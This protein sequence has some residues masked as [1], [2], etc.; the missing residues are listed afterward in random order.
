MA[1]LIDKKNVES[2]IYD[3]RE[4]LVMIDIYLAKLLNEIIFT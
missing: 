1:E 2:F 4:K 3:M